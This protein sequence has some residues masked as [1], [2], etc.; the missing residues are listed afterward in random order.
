VVLAT[1]DTQRGK[2]ALLAPITHSEPS[3][4]GAAIAIP[5]ALKVGLGLDDAPAW[6]ICDEWNIT[7]WPGVDL[8]PVP[9][10]PAGTFHY[11]MLPSGLYEA[12][13][14]LAR[15]LDDVGRARKTP[16]F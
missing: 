1:F 13:R 8:R 5:A 4:P 6:I 7:D 11:G 2:R 9:G 12:A 3:R 14:Q 10:R 16:R 15:R